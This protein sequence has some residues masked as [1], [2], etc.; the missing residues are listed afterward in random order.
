MNL[1]PLTVLW[2]IVRG[3]LKVIF[4]RHTIFPWLLAGISAFISW[5][6]FVPHTWLSGWDTLHPEFN[7]GL[8][9]ERLFFGVFRSEQGLGAVAAHSHMADLPRVILLA[10][11]SLILP[12]SILRYLFIS[13]CLV[14]GAVGIFVFI[15]KS[16]L[17]DA[18]NSNIPAFLGGLFYLFNLGTLQQFYVPFEMFTVQYALLPWLF[19]F[20]T[21]FTFQPKKQTLIF[22]ILAT[23]LSTPMAFAST[24]WFAYFVSFILYLGLFLKSQLRRVAVLISLTLVINSFWLLPTA[25]FVLSGHASAVSSAK[26]NKIFSQEAFTYNKSY[27]I[28]SDTIILWNFLLDWSAYDPQQNNFSYLFANWRQHLARPG[29]L[30]IGYSL[31][32]IALAGLIFGMLSRR[33]VALALILPAL[34]AIIFLINQN[35]P[36]D[37]LFGLFREKIPLFGEAMRFPFTKFSIIFM[38]ALACFFALGQQFL[39]SVV[40]RISSLKLS[41]ILISIQLILFPLLFLIYMWPA[42]T[43][44]FISKKIQVVIPQEYFDMFRWFDNEPDGRV[45]TFPV[46]SFWGWVYYKWGFQGAQFISFGIKQPVMDRDYDRWNQ[47]NEEYFRQISYA[48]Y[49]QNIALMEKVLK[50]YQI[51]YLVLDRN[52]LAPGQ[53]K[54]ALFD[55]EIESLLASSSQ[56]DLIKKFGEISIYRLKSST[57]SELVTNIPGFINV[58]SAQGPQ[59]L[60]WI[61]RDYG[62]YLVNQ[63]KAPKVVLPFRSLIDNQNILKPNLIQAD[64]ENLQLLTELLPK[65]ESLRLNTYLE[66]EFSLPAQLYTKK[67]NGAL[68]LKLVPKLFQAIGKSDAVDLFYLVSNL[69]VGDSNNN[70]LLNIDNYQTLILSGKIDDFADQ[71][72]VFLS[73]N[74][75]NNLAFYNSASEKE[76]K[77]WN[78]VDIISKE[79][80]QIC[81]TVDSNQEVTVTFLGSRGVRL[82]AKN[83]QG[84]VRI[85]VHKIIQKDDLANYKSLMRIRFQIGSSSQAL[86]HYC[87]F[88]NTLGRCVK[89]RDLIPL[90]LVE[91]FVTVDP[92][93]IDILDLVFFLDGVNSKEDIS[94]YNLSFALNKPVGFLTISPEDLYKAFGD[95]QT[96]SGKLFGDYD[97]S[98]NLL[99]HDNK[100]RFCGTISPKKFT[101]TVDLEQGFVEYSS[102]AGSSCDYFAFPDLPHNE[103]YVI[104][105]TNENVF[106]LPLRM[107]VANTFSKRCDLSVALPANTSFATQAFLLPPIN[108]GGV[109]YNVHFD[110]YSVGRI[111]TTNRIKQLKIMPFPYY[112]ISKMGTVQDNITVSN[113]SNLQIKS[114]KQV[115]PGAIILD[116]VN[117]QADQSLLVLNRSYDGGWFGSGGQHVKVNGWANGWLVDSGKAG[118]ML[119]F[120]WPQ[121]L[122]F[123][124]F[125]ILAAAF[126][127]LL[128][129]RLKY[130]LL[131]V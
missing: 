67:K 4:N 131:V 26:V 90:G 119:I 85:P 81:S 40:T 105:V 37:I 2:N 39:Y 52:I 93:R 80:L 110:N 95:L 13:L 125:G 61:Y 3:F 6:S 11:S 75:F 32:G 58:E 73:T 18:K 117:N 25:Y 41:K 111:T 77:D 86:G 56:F 108:D 76:Q 127:V 36:F 5:R 121:L 130:G 83:A 48:V 60:D 1:R 96:Q 113:S 23:L 31:A 74:T 87:I 49:S 57:A 123:L 99:Q 24:L 30:G 89:E 20:A 64:G 71:G 98:L 42:F 107:C 115:F 103:G 19:Y 50:K 29:I 92:L 120:F 112:W 15:K 88:D 10:L 28:F 7:F 129:K 102:E 16:L 104:F 44:D 33:K 47:D 70:L 62:N 126:S 65:G 34:S 122:E 17:Q 43:G 46:N 72:R 54:K 101:R 116:F 14:V 59:D 106:G 84:C 114:V 118:T 79:P 38:L 66:N 35:P 51:N 69:P 63:Q 53:D 91:D 128:T 82:S 97:N 21:S 12:A 100:P 124:G 109:G 27:G 68:T 22:F 8:A 78:L 55:D 45:A 9:F 94:Y